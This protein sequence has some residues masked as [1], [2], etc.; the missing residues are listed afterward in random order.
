MRLFLRFAL[1]VTI[2]LVCFAL[3]SRGVGSVEGAPPD[4]V[5]VFLTVPGK[6]A[7]GD[8]A[9]VNASGGKVRHTFVSSNVISAEVPATAVD[10]LKHNPRFLDVRPVPQITAF[11]DQLVWGVDRI[12]ADRTWGGAQGAVNVSATGNAGQA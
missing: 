9:A 11:E 5:R 3:P 12:E 1:I 4:R 8:V 7:A 10:G 2:S 6:P